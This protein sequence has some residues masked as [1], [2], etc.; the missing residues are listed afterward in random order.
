[1]EAEQHRIADLDH[2]VVDLVVEDRRDAAALHVVERAGV[3]Q[4]SERAAV[5][6]RVHEDPV[7]PL[8]D[9]LSI[10]VEARDHALAQEEHVARGQTEVSRLGECAARGVVGRLARHHV[11]G[12]RGAGPL[13]EPSDP[14]RLEREEGA[15]ADRAER[16][17]ALRTREAEPAALTARHHHQRDPALAQQRLAARARLGAPLRAASELRECLHLGRLELRA[18]LSRLLRGAKPTHQAREIERRRLCGELLLG[19]GCEAIPELQHVS[20]VELLESSLKLPDVGYGGAHAVTSHPRF[21]ER[22]L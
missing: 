7:G 3:E 13:A 2:R 9:Q 19:I 1:V 22:S 21:L 16:V 15:I 17:E 11:P 5:T 20:L 8:E 4:G 14:L 10:E 12:D 18:L 6:V